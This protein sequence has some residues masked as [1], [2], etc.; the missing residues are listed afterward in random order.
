M[1]VVKGS[2]N[3][4]EPRH[5][6]EVI[7]ELTHRPPYSLDMLAEQREFTS[8]KTGHKYTLRPYTPEDK[9]GLVGFVEG[10]SLK[11]FIGRWVTPVSPANRWEVVEDL[12]GPAQNQQILLAIDGKRNIVGVADF[13][14]TPKE[15][16]FERP[17][18]PEFAFAV[19]DA[20]Q[21]EGIGLELALY[22]KDVAKKAGAKG[23]SLYLEKDETAGFFRQVEH[24]LGRFENT[25]NKIYRIHFE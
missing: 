13:T 5:I 12:L 16:E 4:G 11:S 15:A 24:R 10:L 19:A 25:G 7:Q 6:S 1:S 2:G 21:K 9:A 3:P 8:P 20:N 23:F 17:G 22:A 14:I 18:Y